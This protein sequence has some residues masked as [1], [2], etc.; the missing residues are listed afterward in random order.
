MRSESKTAAATPMDP[1]SFGREVGSGETVA[2]GGTPAISGRT[3][4]EARAEKM[5]PKNEAQN[6]NNQIGSDIHFL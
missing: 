3:E 1:T 5:K 2:V 4:V 6:D